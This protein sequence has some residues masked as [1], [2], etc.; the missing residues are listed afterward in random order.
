M[1][2]PLVISNA[3]I[4]ESRLTFNGWLSIEDVK[5]QGLQPL[6]I[7]NAQYAKAFKLLQTHNRIVGRFEEDG[8]KVYRRVGALGYI[9]APDLPEFDPQFVSSVVAA[10]VL[11]GESINVRS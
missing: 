8:T 10:P 1:A 4:I 7:S 9:N 2:S 3:I 5:M 6:C 11:D